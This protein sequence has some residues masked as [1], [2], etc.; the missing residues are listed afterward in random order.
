MWPLWR[1]GFNDNE[2]SALP[3]NSENLAGFAGVAEGLV[4]ATRLPK[5]PADSSE[6]QGSIEVVTEPNT[7]L[8]LQVRSWYDMKLGKEFRTYTLMYGVAAG[9]PAC[10]ERLVTA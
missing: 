4:I 6:I 5:I 3:A 10:I 9:N 8:S 2:Y 7:G 1:H